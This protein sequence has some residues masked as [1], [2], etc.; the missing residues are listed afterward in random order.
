MS[1]SQG[2]RCSFRDVGNGR[3][4]MYLGKPS[5]RHQ[6]RSLSLFGWGSKSTSDDFLKPHANIT[7]ADTTQVASSTTTD[8]VRTVKASHD[9]STAPDPS[10]VHP[11]LA[12]EHTPEALQKLENA[13]V[14]PHNAPSPAEQ[15]ADIPDLASIPERIGYLKEVCAL[16]FGWGPSSMMEWALEHLHLTA[17]LSWANSIIVLGLLF[18]LAVVRPSFVANEQSQK[19]R[20]MQPVLAPLQE[21]SKAA[22]A[23]GDRIGAME[24]QREIG[25]LR[26]EFGLSFGKMFLPIMIQ[27]P[28][29]FAAFRVLSA[30]GNLPV[31]AFE[32]EHW[33][34]LSNIST[35]DP[36]YVLP[37]MISTLTYFNMSRA[38]K[39]Q[40]DNKLA[41]FMKTGLPLLSFLIMIW[42]PASLHLFF[43]V[44]GAFNY[45]QMALFQSAVFR[46]WAG[47]RPIVKATAPSKGPARPT[48]GSM[49]VVIPGQESSAPVTSNRSIIDK[50]VDRVKKSLSDN[51]LTSTYLKTKKANASKSNIKNEQQEKWEIQRQDELEAARRERNSKIFR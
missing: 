11:H 15:L 22:L 43:L 23:S 16:D 46:S 50:G 40:P 10:S 33:L 14:N 42:Q 51:P 5:L 20:E 19:M 48:Y 28:F 29:Q 44:N 4:R 3:H 31:P 2:L 12:N 18:R 17:G 6:S 32:T 1:L 30:A 38:V 36:T 13:I 8:T 26:K 45:G 24:V 25:A 35:T 27:L 9:T 39:S 49:K 7:G 21:R 41:T 37:L 47:L 34:W